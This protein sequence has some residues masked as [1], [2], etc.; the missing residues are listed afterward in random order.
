MLLTVRY[1]DKERKL[2]VGAK[3]IVL[4]NLVDEVNAT[5]CSINLS[6]LGGE[7]DMLLNQQVVYFI[8]PRFTNSCYAIIICRV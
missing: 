7:F 3:D 6:D 8:F 2:Y 4:Q 5:L 1:G